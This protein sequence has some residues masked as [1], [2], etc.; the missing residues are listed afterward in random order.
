MSKR[1]HSSAAP[2][3]C[4]VPR[5]NRFIDGDGAPSHDPRRYGV[6]FLLGV[7]LGVPVVPGA[8]EVLGALDVLGLLP[9]VGLPGLGV[10]PDVLEI[11]GL[12][13]SVTS[14]FA[15]V[16]ASTRPVACSPS[17]FWYAFSAAVVCGPCRPSIGPGSKPL[18]FRACW[19]SRTRW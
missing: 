16:C 10:V 5:R 7:V 6:Y 9:G 13:P 18:S 2:N 11:P 19:T 8:G 17:A 14:I 15:M 1:R 4:P 3:R 12:P